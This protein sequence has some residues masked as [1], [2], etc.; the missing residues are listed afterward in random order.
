MSSGN[1]VTDFTASPVSAMETVGEL[2][3]VLHRFNSHPPLQSGG[4]GGTFSIKL[5]IVVLSFNS[6]HPNVFIS[7]CSE[8]WRALKSSQLKGCFLHWGTKKHRFSRTLPGFKGV[9]AAQR[10]L[11][12]G[13]EGVQVL[14][15]FRGCRLWYG[16]CVNGE[17]S[18]LCIIQVR[19][20]RPPPAVTKVSW[21]LGTQT[22]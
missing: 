4:V 8:E 6:L 9:R 17:C 7:G 3:Q 22:K 2:M 11:A 16:F 12:A 5:R 20:G 10:S 19:S 15:S 13:F 1:E 18:S 14:A 21:L